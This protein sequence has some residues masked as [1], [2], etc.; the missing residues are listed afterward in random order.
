MDNDCCAQ[1]VA[2]ALRAVESVQGV[3]VSTDGRA[4][5]TSTVAVRPEAVES[6]LKTA[7]YAA[8]KLESVDRC[9]DGL[10]APAQDPWSGIVD[11]DVKVISHGEE[12]DLAAHAATGKFTVYDFGADWCAP[13]HTTAAALQA[14]LRTHPDVAVRAILL[15]GSDAAASFALPIVKQHLQFAPGLPYLLVRAPNGKTVYQGPDVTD[16]LASVDRKRR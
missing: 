10:R 3:Y 14:Y 5:V 9:P 13:C 8:I 1:Q 12:T 4:C 15:D 2:V 11:L 16:A 6:A 7:G